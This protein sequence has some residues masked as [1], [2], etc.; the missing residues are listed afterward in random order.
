MW[1]GQRVVADRSSHGDSRMNRG[2]PALQAM[3]PGAVKNVR[4]TDRGCRGRDFDPREERVIIHDRIGKEGFVDAAT[5]E[6]ER[7]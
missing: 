3:M 1:R 6:V 2:S 4:D 5:A 7:G